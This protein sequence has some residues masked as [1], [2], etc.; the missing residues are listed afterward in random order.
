MT[1]SLRLLDTSPESPLTSVF[2][3]CTSYFSSLCPLSSYK[4]APTFSDTCYSSSPL[5]GTE[6]CL[7]RLWLLY[8]MLQTAG[9]KQQTD[10]TSHSSRGGE[11]PDQG[12]SS[13]GLGEDSPP[14]LQMAT[15]SLCPH[16]SLELITELW[17]PLLFLI[18]FLFKVNHF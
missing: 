5:H 4:A 14:G 2:L 3:I 15:F 17:P 13:S 11:C 6:I 7:T 18:F 8:K 16:T 10:I 9:L 1:C 12:A